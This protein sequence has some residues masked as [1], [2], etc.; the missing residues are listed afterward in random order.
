MLDIV[1]A[2]ALSAIFSIDV[3][4]LIGLAPVRPGVKA[5]AFALAAAWAAAVVAITAAGGFAPGVAGPL[6]TA[7]LP[8]F[9]LVIGGL[10]AWLMW[11][12]FRNAL[13]ALPLAALVGINSLRIGGVFFLILHASGRLS[14]PFATSAGWGDI[15]TGVAAIPLAA[16]LARGRMPSKIVLGTWNAFGTLD[17]IV[18]VTLGVLSAAGTQFQVFTEP[19]GTVALTTLPWIGVPTILVPLYLLT[20]LT[21]AAK[22]RLPTVRRHAIP[23][24]PEQVPHIE[25]SEK[26][27][28]GNAMR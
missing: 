25:R 7:A 2:L 20:H 26:L 23:A 3:I 6:P 13:V 21:I 14:A 27:A 11:P 1:G 18:A 24:P 4:V 22:L 16:M 8:F 15:I 10:V 17:L 9:A 19:P 28:G 5:V 12:A